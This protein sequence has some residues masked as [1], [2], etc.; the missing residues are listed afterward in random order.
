M[1]CVPLFFVFTF[2]TKQVNYCSLNNY[3]AG[4]KAGSYL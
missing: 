4:I 2:S 3:T 1:R